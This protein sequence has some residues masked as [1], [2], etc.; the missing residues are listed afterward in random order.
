MS[1]PDLPE[2]AS[3]G[4]SEAMNLLLNRPDPEEGQDEQEDE[5]DAPPPV[6][7]ADEDDDSDQV[8]ASDE[9]D[10]DEE[11]ESGGEKFKIK[12]SELRAGYMKDADYRRK[13]AEVAE[14]RRAVRAHAQ[15]IVQE[16]QHAANQLDVILESLRS[17]LIGRQPDPRLIDDDPQEYLRQQTAYNTRASQFQT[18]LQ[19]RQA[20]TQQQNAEAQRQQAEYQAEQNKKLVE[21]LPAWKDEKVRAQEAGEIA[22]YLAELGYSNDELNTLADHRALLVARDAAKY[23]QLQAA[24][25]KRAPQQA[26]KPVKPGAARPA[27]SNQTRYDDALARARK[28][29]R[30]ED[31]HRV[32]MNKGR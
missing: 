29:G 20:V 26:G 27:S 18:A 16:R 10:P 19:Q 8:K 22:R 1:Q 6:D 2:L 3:A 12:R 4:E 28:T 11:W 25:G 30:P 5:D 23:R 32:L 15:Q 13:T 9:D 14:E 7:E 31:I 24:K 17:E 21:A